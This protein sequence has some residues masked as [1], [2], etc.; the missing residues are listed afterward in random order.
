MEFTESQKGK[1]KVLHSGYIY[2][3][4]KDLANDIRSFECELR[5]KGQCNARVKLTFNNN[6]VEEMNE[7]THTPSQDKVELAKV[8]TNL[9]HRAERT[10]EPVNRIIADELAT[11][12]QTTA[13][14]LPRV[15]HLRRTLRHQRRDNDRPPNPIARAAIPEI[16]LAYQQTS[17]GERFLLFDSGFGDDNRMLIFATDQALQLLANSEDWF[18]DCTFCVRPEIFFQLYTVHTRVG[19]RII[20]CIFAL[21]PNKTR[22]TY[23]GTTE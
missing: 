11:A 17:N 4:Q 15:E 21:L 3:F 6:I 10:L 5:R 2:A 20:P 23:N 1:Q 14:N 16:P 19:Q 12:S 8:Q 7:H 22:E 18:C 9:K 13:T